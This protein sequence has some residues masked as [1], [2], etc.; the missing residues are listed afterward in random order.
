MLLIVAGLPKSGKSRAIDFLS[1]SDGQWHIIRPSD[2][3]PENLSS[4]DVESQRA[5]NIECWS[6]AIEKC[7]EAIE[8]VPPRETIVLDSCNSKYTTLL[9]LIVDAKAAMH[10]VVL[11]FVQSNISLCLARD[12]KMTESL[13]CDYTNRFKV[14]L[15][16]YKKSC[17]SFLV[18]RN[19]GTLDQLKTELHNV[20]K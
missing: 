15:P 16:K 9:T 17:D 4:L 13:L 10:K 14:S 5:F 19:N 20:W 2:W 7:K 1:K 3:I 18:I 8:Q 11:L 6:M 12:P